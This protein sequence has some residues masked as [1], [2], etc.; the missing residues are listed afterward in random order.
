MF[1][2]AISVHDVPFQVSTIAI[3]G[4]P[5]TAIAAVFVAPSPVAS[6]LTLFKSATSVQD[7]PFQV[8]V[9]PVLDGAF[10]PKTNAAV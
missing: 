7:V 10:P 6:P 2:S 8:S 4:T 1:I 9:A 3:V 5:P